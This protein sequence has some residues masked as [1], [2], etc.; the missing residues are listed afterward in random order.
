M[1]A[2]A[3]T[4]APLLDICLPVNFR[5]RTVNV[6]SMGNVL[7]VDDNAD[8]QLVTGDLVRLLRCE[9][10]AATSLREAR[11]IAST[12][13]FDLT[14]VELQLPDGNGLDLPDD[15]GIGEHCQ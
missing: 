12:A 11:R 14:M 1:P 8:F 5:R 4:G 3:C 9:V 15:N 6:Q 10:T 7:I 2:L 13:R